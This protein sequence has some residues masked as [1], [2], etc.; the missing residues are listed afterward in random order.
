MASELSNIPPNS[1][2]RSELGDNSIFGLDVQPVRT[3]QTA[4]EM[5]EALSQAVDDM[6]LTTDGW[7]ENAAVDLSQNLNTQATLPRMSE[8]GI[9]SAMASGAHPTTVNLNRTDSQASSKSTQGPYTCNLCPK[10]CVKKSGLVSHM[11]TH[12]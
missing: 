12:K 10:I 9:G 1:S 4:A 7:A 8:S 6:D 11:K 5:A 2:A 3:Q